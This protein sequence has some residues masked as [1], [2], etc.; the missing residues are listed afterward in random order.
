MARRGDRSPSRRAGQRARRGHDRHGRRD[1]A[2]TFDHVVVAPPR[3]RPIPGDDHDRA[4]RRWFPGHRDR[5]TPRVPDHGVASGFS[6]PGGVTDPQP[7]FAALADPTR[8]R[9]L[10][11]LSAAGPASAS[12]LA[13]EMPISRQA[14]AKHLALLDEAGLVERVRSGREVQYRA[15]PEALDDVTSWVAR[16]GA[17]WDER[18]EKLKRSLE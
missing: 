3:R 15:R 9:V 10:D 4:Q 14:I 6:R 18:L 17:Q 7:L 12:K 16:V 5:T 8:R 1:R 13:A 2:G 11:R